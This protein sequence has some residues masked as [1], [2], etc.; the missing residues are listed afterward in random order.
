MTVRPG[1]VVRGDASGLV[2]VQKEH[3]APVLA[4]TKTVADRE[5]AWRQAIA[6]GAR[7]PAAT[8]ID[9]LISGLARDRAA[10]SPPPASP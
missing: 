6:G 3:L 10:G 1:D 8:G 5:E 9:D 7:L 2:V 4:M